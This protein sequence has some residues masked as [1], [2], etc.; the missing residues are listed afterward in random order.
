MAR[1]IV[2]L[3]I[4]LIYAFNAA[5]DTRSG[6]TIYRAQLLDDAQNLRIMFKM[7]I[8][9][10]TSLVNI[11]DEMETMV[12]NVNASLASSAEFNKRIKSNS[13]TM[14]IQI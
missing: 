8:F 10:T 3:I 11:R 2:L 13:G 12:D 7:L 14:R 1:P 9:L 4:Q 5:V 6:D